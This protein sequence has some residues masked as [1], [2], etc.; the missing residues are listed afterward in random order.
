MTTPPNP[1]SVHGKTSATGSRR[2]LRTSPAL[3]W[4][5]ARP[6][7]RR[8][9]AGANNRN[10]SRA[11]RRRRCC[12]RASSAASTSTTSAPSATTARRTTA[13]GG[14][15]ARHSAPRGAARRGA[16]RLGAKRVHLH[17]WKAAGPLKTF[18]VLIN[19]QSFRKFSVCGGKLTKSST[20]WLD[21]RMASRR[22]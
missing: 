12:T 4:T 16:A 7:E 13:A 19:F 9:A 15:A 8:H 18:Q 1:R 22:E 5:R 14:Q 2:R 20:P 6:R 3:G 17:P 21:F 11:T 10:A